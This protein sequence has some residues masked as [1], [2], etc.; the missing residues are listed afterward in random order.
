MKKLF[1]LLIALLLLLSMSFSVSAEAKPVFELD[2]SDSTCIKNDDKAPLS[3]GSLE[4][5]DGK[6][7]LSGWTKGTTTAANYI[8]TA[9]ILPD[10]L[11][12]MGTLTLEYEFIPQD[13]SWLCA[14]VV[15]GDQNNGTEQDAV[16]VGFNGN[17]FKLDVRGQ[18]E[19]NMGGIKTTLGE[20]NTGNLV[21]DMPY[22][23]R[24][25]KDNATG[26][27]DL[28]FYEKEGKVPTEPT[29]SV[30]SD[31]IK[32]ISGNISFTGYAG[33]YFVDNV[34]VWKDK[35]PMPTNPPTKAPTTTTSAATAVPS[36]GDATKAPTS[37]SVTADTPDTNTT[38]AI[39]Q[40]NEQVTDSSQTVLIVVLCVAGVVVIGA[41]VAIV[42]MYFSFKKKLDE[43]SKQ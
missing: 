4:V 36:E 12:P 18:I 31:T 5:V 29:L 39:N 14:A 2:F 38:N 21:P 13:V 25:Y 23:V 16:I 10:E 43:A 19:L 37:G 35:A 33:R 11:V 42:L 1:P 40:D 24:V 27:M 41:I 7:K 20:F 15:I 28:Y 26:K 30:Q 8:K 6:A 32:T 34:K 3:K 17:D 9:G 22:I